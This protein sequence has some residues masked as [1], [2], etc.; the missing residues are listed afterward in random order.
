M[1]IRDVEDPGGLEAELDEPG[2]DQLGRV[3]LPG[4]R[5]KLGPQD[6]D[7]A[8]VVEP[9]PLEDLVGRPVEVDAVD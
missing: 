4:V 8:A 3:H 2:Q 5:G 6:A 7:R 1:A 9:H